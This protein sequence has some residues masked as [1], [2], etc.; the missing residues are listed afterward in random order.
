MD[1][2]GQMKNKEAYTGKTSGGVKSL[3]SVRGSEKNPAKENVFWC[4]YVEG[5][6]KSLSQ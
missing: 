4:E 2:K 3:C 6:C 5:H 1:L